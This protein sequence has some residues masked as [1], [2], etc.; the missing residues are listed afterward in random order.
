MAEK[1][2]KEKADRILAEVKKLREKKTVTVEEETIKIVIVTLANDYYAFF[3][4]DV[5]K[6]LPHKE[7]TYVPGSPSF[8]HGIINVSGDIESVV[9]IHKLLSL[10]EAQTTRKTRNRR[11]PRQTPRF[12]RQSHRTA[13]VRS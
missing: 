6:I 9:N 2:D 12:T 1:P 7:I 11:H 13:N 5:K 3:G 10:S 4:D 8:I